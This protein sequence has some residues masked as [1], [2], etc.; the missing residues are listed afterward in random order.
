MGCAFGCCCFGFVAVAL[1]FLRPV[2]FGLFLSASVVVLMCALSGDL[3]PLSGAVVMPASSFIL[4]RDVLTLGLFQQLSLLFSENPRFACG[5][6][7][8]VLDA[9]GGG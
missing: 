8:P 9:D 1:S 3:P 7:A 2:C 6:S 4:L 5:F